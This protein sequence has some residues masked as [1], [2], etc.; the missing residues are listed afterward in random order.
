MKLVNIFYRRK[1]AT[2]V[3]A[4]FLASYRASAAIETVTGSILPSKADYHKSL[5]VEQFDPALG[6]LQ[7]VTITATGT[8]QLD[9]FYKNRSPQSPGRVTISQ[10]LDMI[11]NMPVPSS[12]LLDLKQTETH[13]YSRLPVY[14]ESLQSFAG[15][16]SGLQPYFFTPEVETVL[17]SDFSQF[18]GSGLATFLVTATSSGNASHL[19]GFF[20]AGFST[21]AGLDLSVT[22]DYIP[23]QTMIAV[24][25]PSTWSWLAGGFAVASLSIGINQRRLKTE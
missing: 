14:D 12:P 19:N 24:P 20:S 9:Q 22:Y 25:E 3:V 11:V 8:G 16:S 4:G 1:L 17:S 13:T 5:L 15:S 10:T 21:K 2:I 23:L 7:S 18:I 6:T